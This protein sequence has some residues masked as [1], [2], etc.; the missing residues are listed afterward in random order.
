MSRTKTKQEP[1]NQD[2]TALVEEGLVWEVAKNAMVDATDSESAGSMSTFFHHRWS[3][4]PVAFQTG[5]IQCK[6]EIHISHSKY[7][8][9]YTKHFLKNKQVKFI[10]K[11]KE[12]TNGIFYCFVLFCTVF[13]LWCIFHTC[14]TSQT[15]PAMFQ[16][17]VAA[18]VVRLDRTSLGHAFIQQETSPYAMSLLPIFLAV[19]NGSLG[20]IP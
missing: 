19:P 5:A 2:W 3:A 14:S 9:T 20:L 10:F 8:S 15:R 11:I 12:V 18:C 13:E 6:H 4:L 1:A 17:S 16:G 7:S